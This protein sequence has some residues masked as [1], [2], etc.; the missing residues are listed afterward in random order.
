MAELRD[1]PEENIALR[2]R[3]GWSTG[4][5]ALTFIGGAVLFIA[6]I[7][8]AGLRFSGLT[9]AVLIVAGFVA[10]ALML[11]SASAVMTALG[12]GNR[13][14]ALGM[15]EGSIR[16]MIAMVL[17]LMFAIIGIV[18]FNAATSEEQFTSSG[19]SQ[20]QVDQVRAGGMIVLQQV[21]EP[22]AAVS[23]A[24]EPLY[25]VIVRPAMTPASHDFGLQLLTTVSTLVVA[26][27]GF[28]FGSRA[29]D[30]AIRAAK[31]FR[32]PPPPTPGV[33]GTTPLGD[34]QDAVSDE[35]DEVGLDELDSDDPDAFAGGDGDGDLGDGDGVGDD[36]G[37]GVG[38]D[39][40]DGE[41]SGDEKETGPVG[42]I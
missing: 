16:A 8:F 42:G 28:Y 35:G 29:T 26:V 34:G 24:P 25:T 40:D 1:E 32:P 33:V 3:M 19:L 13:T 36:A 21:L 17:I 15:P 9:G 30:R 11:L 39:A 12:M 2:S 14:E 20:A 22:A 6:L 23:P 7:A 41:A 5:I 4:L 31:D 37:D 10:V 18:V 38:D 27:A